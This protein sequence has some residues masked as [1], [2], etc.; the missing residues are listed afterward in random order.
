M[1]TA[2]MPIQPDG[3]WW[4]AGCDAEPQD[5]FFAIQAREGCI[6]WEECAKLGWKVIAVK[7]TA[8]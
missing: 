7:I 4:I 3:E 5:A 6:S 2:Y 1:K 8:L